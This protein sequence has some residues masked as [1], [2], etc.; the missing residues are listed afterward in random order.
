MNTD[1]SDNIETDDLVPDEERWVEITDR[2]EDGWCAV[3]T[4]Y[5]PSLHWWGVVLDRGEK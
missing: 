2:T 4:D 3:E 5:A 1:W